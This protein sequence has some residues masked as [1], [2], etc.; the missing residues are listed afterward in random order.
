[1]GGEEWTA[2]VRRAAVNYCISSTAALVHAQHLL[3][4]K[5]RTGYAAAGRWNQTD[6]STC[7]QGSMPHEPL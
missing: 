3:S 2:V 5:L 4:G 1:M 7:V 6:G